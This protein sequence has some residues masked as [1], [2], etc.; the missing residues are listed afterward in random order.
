[1]SLKRQDKLK[2]PRWS[3][4][5][6]SENWL[7]KKWIGLHW[8]KISKVRGAAPNDSTK[9]REGT[10]Q[11]AIAIIGMSGRFP[12]SPN[13]D[14]FWENIRVNKD[15]ISEIPA[16]RWDWRAHYGE[17][18]EGKTKVKW[19]GFI[20]DVDQFDPLFFNISPR[21]AELMDPQHR[22]ALEAT[23]HALEDAGLPLE[24]IK[25]SRT[26][27][28]FGLSS[29]DYA[30]S[31]VKYGEGVTR[32]Q[33]AV[34]GAHSMLVNR[35]SYLLDL[36]GP[37]EPIDTACSSSLIAIHRAVETICNGHCEMAIV[38]GVNALLHPDLL[39]S[40]DQAGM[41]SEDGRCKT[42][43]D[44][45]DGYV[46]G[47]GVGVIILK[48]ASKALADGDRIHALI[49]STAENHGGKA[50][51]LTSP[52]PLAQKGLLLKAYR[53]ADI[54]PRE[55]SYIEA[56]GTGTKLGDPMEARGLKMA[57]KELYDE[58]QLPLPSAP[59]ISL[60]SVKTNIGH[61][62]SAA[63]IAGVL[64]VV[65]A[66]KHKTLPGNPHLKQ[67][68]KYLRLEQSPFKLLQETI[69]W[70]TTGNAPR[71]AGVSGFG[72]GG[73]N[74]HIVIEEF[75][76]EASAYHSE[77]PAVI[78]LSAKNI[79]RLNELAAGLE[80]LLI[81]RPSINLHDLAYTLQMG[82]AAMEER[83]AFTADTI[84][85]VIVRLGQFV[86]GKTKALFTGNVKENKT[87][88]ML[89]GDAG[90][91][92][93][94]S[95]IKERAFAKLSQLWVLGIA[96]DWS[97]LYA[98]PHHPQKI[99]LTPYPFARRAYWFEKTLE[100]VAPIPGVTENK[101]KVQLS[102]I[103]STA[104]NENEKHSAENL[105]NGLLTLLAK[106][107]YIDEEE[108]SMDEKFVDM[109]MDS[110]IGVEFVKTLN[111]LF[112]IKLA[113]TDLYNYPTPSALLNYLAKQVSQTMPAGRELEDSNIPSTSRVKLINLPSVDQEIPAL[114]K[115][116]KEVSEQEAI[117]QEPEW[118]QQDIA[119]VGMSGR[120]PGSKDIDSLWKNLKEGKD[121][122][123]EVP[124]TRWNMDAHY[125]E[126][127]SVAG[128]SY[129]KWMGCLSDVDVFDP[130][131]FHI[132]PKEAE[133]MDPQQRLLLEESWKAIEDAGYN[134]Y[135][136]SE[137]LCGVFIGV[138]AGDYG[139]GCRK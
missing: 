77:M 117:A 40:F 34:G 105:R 134:P 6:L 63:G 50:R 112:S 37:S 98:E 31:Q 122:I 124:S 92:F 126:D 97:L 82:R 23:Y 72:F 76:Q 128:K 43:D 119:I 57:F 39:L 90:K 131:F 71:I 8:A 114:E 21:E 87:K 85:E 96:V 125:D 2:R 11:E 138:G 120:F 3:W 59:H 89:Q 101:S 53:A 54:D 5:S 133:L 139:L 28:F 62:E 113:P 17:K 107:L 27:V 129:S 58:R 108:L 60:G 42:F 93:I 25:G 75:R 4:G 100:S 55:V 115:T 110:I 135:S 103:L 81:S 14:V 15:L 80:D 49:R 109:G 130:L 84:E 51:T 65:L 79:E 106:S 88:E 16:S 36:N 67:P 69:P 1:M 20:S 83:L 38:G 61:L 91:E 30:L 111:D 33:S 136:L 18:E 19:G 47:E 73:A 99:S 7:V 12:G 32:A 70:E 10:K 102:N 123:V 56:H 45:A 66:L 9:M 52:N 44:S 116:T 48:A 64:K 26:A 68:N 118:K 137:K 46:R 41:L 35:I 127:Q 95:A 132:S 13:L 94:K 24:G 22:I 121:L 86:D 78:L 74:A 104:P 29:Y